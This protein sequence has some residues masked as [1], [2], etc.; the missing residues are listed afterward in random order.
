MN[1]F[2]M[3]KVSFFRIFLSSFCFAIASYLFT[4]FSF[5]VSNNIFHLPIIFRLFDLDQFKED[6]FIQSLRHYSSGLWFLLN[7]AHRLLDIEFLFLVLFIFSRILFFGGFFLCCSLFSSLA[8]KDLF[9]L[10]TLTLVT[11]FVYGMSFAGGGGLFIDSFTHSELANGLVLIFVF[12]LA[13]RQFGLALAIN[14]LCFFLNCFMALWNFLPF[15]IVLIS[16]LFNKNYNMSFLKSLLVGLLI[17]GCCAFPVVYNIISNPYIHSDLSFSFREYLLFYFPQHSLAESIPFFEYLKLS[18]LIIIT[19]FCFT[20]L[21]LVGK[22]FFIIFKC[23]LLLYLFGVLVSFLCPSVLMLNCHLLR[24]SVVFH[25]AATIAI[26][27]YLFFYI[28]NAKHLISYLFPLVLLCTLLSDFTSILFTPLMLLRG[29]V[30]VLFSKDRI[31]FYFRKPLTILCFLF[32]VFYWSVFAGKNFLGSLRLNSRIDDLIEL[33]SWIK[34][35]T[36]TNSV[37]ILPT[38]NFNDHET[39]YSKGFPGR[40]FC[41]FSVFQSFSERRVFVDF[42]R[43][44]AVM[45]CPEYFFEWKPRVDSILQYMNLD[46]LV[47]FA[48]GEKISYIIYDLTLYPEAPAFYKTRFFGLIKVF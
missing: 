17:F 27:I 20:R 47:F 25:L 33:S 28:K 9:C 3:F 5:G 7:G 36:E 10:G 1:Y 29:K 37:F 26:S 38:R 24:S 41:D 13:Q 45:W 35:N 11:P 4:G 23:Y 12:F 14:G 22:E 15:G 30:V 6:L 16:Y 31:A 39:F 8:W 19:F 32:L 2:A 48:R 21:G 18:N 43:G 42:K 40:G 44:A 34:F 46:D